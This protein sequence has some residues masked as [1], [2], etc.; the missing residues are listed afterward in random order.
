MFWND[1]NNDIF[2][3][4]SIEWLGTI[5]TSNSFEFYDPYPVNGGKAVLV[6][7]V[8]GNYAKELEDTFG[9]DTAAY[10]T[11][12]TNQAMT[13]LRSMFSNSIPDPMSSRN[14]EKMTWHMVHIRS[15][16]LECLRKLGKTCA[17]LFKTIVS[18]LQVKLVTTIILELPMVSGPPC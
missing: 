7:F 16:R 18:S 10:Q 14:G 1:T 5:A 12:M 4:K 3:P 17:H 11:E 2:W 9:T 15:I 13:G 6:A 8:Y